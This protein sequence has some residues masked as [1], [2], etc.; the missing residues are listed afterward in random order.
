MNDSE[1]NFPFLVT[2]YKYNYNK[3]YVYC[4]IPFYY[5]KLHLQFSNTI[6]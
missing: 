4:T 3:H 6:L 1:S 5:T 2:F